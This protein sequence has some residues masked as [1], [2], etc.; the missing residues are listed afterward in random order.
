MNC[1]TGNAQAGTCRRD[2]LVLTRLNLPSAGFS[3]KQV[4]EKIKDLARGNGTDP[5]QWAIGY[6]ALP[7]FV[8]P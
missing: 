7:L 3:I 1:R 5:S 4:Q 6:K 8:K 2:L